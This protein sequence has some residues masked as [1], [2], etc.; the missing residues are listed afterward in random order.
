[1]TI[2]IKLKALQK[3]VVVAYLKYCKE[4]LHE[5]LTDIITTHQNV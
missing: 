3:E 1:M 5:R 4:I 2:R